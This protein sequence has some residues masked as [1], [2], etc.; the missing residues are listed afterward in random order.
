MDT[1]WIALVGTLFGGAALK[2][3]EGLFA[4]GTKTV[5][6]ATNLRE[7]LRKEST[8]LKE[9]IR[10]AEHELDNW[11][12]KYYKLYQEYIDIKQQVPKAP[13]DR[14]GEGEW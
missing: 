13:V 6:L 3:V 7:E 10:V 1:A 5:D 4:K 9:E 2:I 12:E 8:Q 14:G 11:K